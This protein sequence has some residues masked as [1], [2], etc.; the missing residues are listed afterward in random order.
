MGLPIELQGQDIVWQE[1]RNIG[2][3][4]L[5][6]RGAKEETWAFCSLL[7]HLT[8]INACCKIQPNRLPHSLVVLDFECFKTDL[9]QS[10][11]LINARTVYQGPLPPPPMHWYADKNRSPPHSFEQNTVTEIGNNFA[12]IG[13][14]WCPMHSDHDWCVIFETFLPHLVQVIRDERSLCLYLWE[15]SSRPQGGLLI[16]HVDYHST[17]SFRMNLGFQECENSTHHRGPVAGHDSPSQRKIKASWRNKCSS[18][19]DRLKLCSLCHNETKIERNQSQSTIYQTST[20]GLS[21]VFDSVEYTWLACTSDSNKK[22]VATSSRRRTHKGEGLHRHL[23]A[24]NILGRQSYFLEIV[25]L[26]LL[27]R[28][29]IAFICRKENTFLAFAVQEQSF[30]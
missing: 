16:M 19:T 5:F 11:Q 14:W 27:L 12:P 22:S 30:R 18:C 20:S 10:R 25:G 23:K 1:G 28:S 17:L 8:K 13:R 15:S 7:M 29:S 3:S 24:C 21:T 2:V 4:F 6:P 9:R 26:Y